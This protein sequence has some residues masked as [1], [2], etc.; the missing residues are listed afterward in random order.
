MR[1]TNNHNISL[2]LA[3][4]LLADDY[5]YNNNPNTISATSLL[6]STKQIILAK[7]VL[8]EDK[9]MDIS[10]RIASAFG[11]AVHDSVQKAWERHGQSG[12]K[13][14]GYP[15]HVTQ[16]I[17][18]NPTDEYLAAN[19][20]A[21]LI[22]FERRASNKIIINGVEY[23]ITGK[24]DTVMDGHLFDYKTTS[25]F[26]YT[27]GSKDEDYA[28]QGSIYRWLNPELITE[29][30]IFI[31][32]IFT[33]WQKFMVRSNPNYPKL[34]LLEHPV[35]LHSLE[36]TEK[37]ISNKLNELSRLWDKSEVDLPPCTDKELWRS[38]PEYKYYSDPAKANQPGSRSTKN[39]DN[40]LAGANAHMA[41]QGKGI[42]KT[43]PGQVKACSYCPAYLACEQRKQ[44]ENV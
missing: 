20:N 31:N 4:W 5:D 39:F 13:K 11:N 36:D 42:V 26:S 6:R 9:E 3:V 32:F 12:L 14:L 24:F 2:P 23:T 29:D 25:T 10:E 27:S 21:I 38:E 44:Y 19:P 30:F 43:I 18:I 17:V 7:H 1:I 37:F 35:K 28:L 16:N 33:D 41:A 34:K 40:D 15:D 8:S 22:F